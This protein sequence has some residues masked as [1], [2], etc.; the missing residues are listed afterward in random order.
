MS[1]A[2]K[3]TEKVIS[4]ADATGAV[5]Q[6]LVEQAPQAWNGLVVYHR[7]HSI[8]ELIITLTIFSFGVFCLHRGFRLAKANWNLDR[9]EV[10]TQFQDVLD[11]FGDD[12]SKKIEEQNHIDPSKVMVKTSWSDIND[13]ADKYHEY[14]VEVASYSAA[15]FLVVG[16]ICGVFSFVHFSDAI[17]NVA[18]P[19]RAAAM[20]IIDKVR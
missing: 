1:N 4:M 16:F 20:E 19:E 7:T 6:S 3:I 10:R 14:R 17:A 5:I 12:L 11:K 8:V 15:G 9:Y 18:V 13:F 2:D